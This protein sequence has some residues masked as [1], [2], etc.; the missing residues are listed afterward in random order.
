LL[1]CELLGWNARSAEVDARKE[2]QVRIEEGGR[3]FRKH[4]WIPEPHF[5]TAS[6]LLMLRA[7]AVD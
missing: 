7:S 1:V 2:P 6:L 3:R 4:P 5:G